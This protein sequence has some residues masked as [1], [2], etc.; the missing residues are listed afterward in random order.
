[1]TQ[2]PLAGTRGLWG[3][4]RRGTDPWCA[5]GGQRRPRPGLQAR[6]RGG[7][8]GSGFARRARVPGPVSAVWPGTE[9]GEVDGEGPGPEW[10]Q[11][12]APGGITRTAHMCTHART[13]THMHTHTHAQTHTPPPPGEA[14][15]LALR[16]PRQPFPGPVGRAAP[17][18]HFTGGRATATD[19]AAL[20]IQVRLSSG[21]DLEQPASPA[22]VAC[23]CASPGSVLSRV[24]WGLEG[25]SADQSRATPRTVRKPAP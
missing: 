18:P 6:G 14:G 9:E 17:C 22:A 3:G 5:E 24:E 21:P 1:M 20:R 23:R 13:R 8:L 10:P 25:D 19:G 4:G 12:T 16:S 11:G 15:P 2:P 7:W